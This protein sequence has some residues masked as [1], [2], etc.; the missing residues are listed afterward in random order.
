M[1]GIYG[2]GGGRAMAAWIANDVAFFDPNF[3]EFYFVDKA[4]FLQW[5]PTYFK[6]SLYS[7][8]KVGLCERYE[9]FVYAKRV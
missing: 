8:P 5:L 4:N 6:K 7:L 1:I 9:T 2:P 3:G